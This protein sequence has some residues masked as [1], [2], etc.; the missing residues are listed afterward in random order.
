MSIT[1][2]KAGIDANIL[3]KAG[4]VDAITVAVIGA[5]Y[6]DLADLLDGV[7]GGVVPADYD[8]LFKISNKISSIEALVGAG[9]TDGDTLVDTVTEI[10]TVFATY[11]EGTDILS[12]LNSKVATSN[13][14]NTLTETTSGKV[15]DARQGKALYDLLLAK[16]DLTYVNTQVTS[17]QTALDAL[18]A[19]STETIA[20]LKTSINTINTLIAAGTTD[21]DA[22]VN[23]VTELLAVFSTYPEGVNLLTTLNG[24]VNTADVVNVLTTTTTGKV[25]DARQGKTLNDSIAAIN[26]A[27]GNK[28]DLSGG[29]V[30]TAQLPDVALLPLLDSTQF[31][32][33]NSKVRI[34]PSVLGS[35]GS[36]GSS[37]IANLATNKIYLWNFLGNSTNL[38]GNWG[39]GQP[40]VTT[41]TARPITGTFFGQFS[42]IATVSAATAGA[43]CAIRGTIRLFQRGNAPKVGGFNILFKCGVSDAAAV[44][45]GRNAWGLFDQDGTTTG[46]LQNRN[47]SS[48]INCC[49]VGSDSGDANLQI[50]HNDGTG[51]CTKIDLGVDFPANTLSTDM[52]QVQIFAEPNGSYIEVTVTN[53]L[54]GI[55]SPTH[56]LTTNLPDPAA[57]MPLQFWRNNGTTAAAVSLDVATVYVQTEN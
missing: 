41:A 3:A 50:M 52:Y 42:R 46:T 10:L 51:T 20:S 15:L 29:K 36:G 44:A 34:I 48:E 24:K 23:T 21:G 43:S 47:P 56:S 54:T 7:I 45:Q 11:P 57:I 30:P 31:E 55:V 28:A 25:L 2:Y 33:F 32:E 5:A 22:F 27:L 13:V 17:V 1:T 12:V 49:F 19:G 39:M 9:I 14:V 6:K 16:A 40:S 53:L 18:K 38:P 4:I 35:G 26:V 37:G 8:S